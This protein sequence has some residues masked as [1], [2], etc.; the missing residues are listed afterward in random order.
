MELITIIM[1]AYNCEKTVSRS[2]ESILKQ[3]YKKFEVIIVNDGSTDRTKSICESFNDRRI[4]VITTENGGPSAARNVALKESKGKYIM[5]I[6]SDDIY[7][8]NALEVMLEK[9]EKDGYD[10]V[11]ANYISFDKRNKKYYKRTKALETQKKNDIYKYID[12]LQNKGLFNTNWNKIY[13]SEIIKKNKI[14]FDEKKEI[15]EDAKFNFEYMKYVKRCSYISEAIYNY[16]LNDNGLTIK[17]KESRAA[18]LLN[19]F[20]DQLLYY[21]QQKYPIDNIQLRIFKAFFSINDIDYIYGS[22]YCNIIDSIN[23]KKWYL[24][25]LNK[26]IKRKCDIRLK[27]LLKIY[28][29]L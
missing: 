10:I 25:S 5:F 20:E 27:M 1:P 22:K 23:H 2:V 19:F 4:K 12:Y 9:I 6:D 26:W 17:N 29:L 11:T 16:Y 28:E 24:R 7:I 18:R 13:K 3:T 14:L 8:E 15:G 21:E